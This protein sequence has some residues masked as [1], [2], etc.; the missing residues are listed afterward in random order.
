MVGLPHRPSLRTQTYFRLLCHKPFC[1]SSRN[2]PETGNRTGLLDG[3]HSL[4]CKVQKILKV[5]YFDIDCVTESRYY[6][7]NAYTVHSVSSERN[8]AFSECVI[9]YGSMKKSWNLSPASDYCVLPIT[10]TK[11]GRIRSQPKGPPK[12]PYTSVSQETPRLWAHRITSN[13]LHGESPMFL[14]NKHDGTH[15]YGH[16]VSVRFSGVLRG[17]IY[18]LH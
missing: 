12:V 3:L 9:N 4:G 5:P 18:I 10:I 6:F 2:A 8:H 16:K 15:A 11:L 14:D 17:G 13:D 1:V 7:P